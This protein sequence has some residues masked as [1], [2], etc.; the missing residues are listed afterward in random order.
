MIVT[1]HNLK[2]LDDKK[3]VSDY[4]T[5]QNEQAFSSL[6]NSKTPRLYKTALRLTQNEG[7]A[8]EIIQQMWVVA[9]RKLDHFEWRSELTTWLT[10]ILFNLY[11]TLRKREEKMTELAPN[12]VAEMEVIKPNK[13]LSMDLESAISQLPPGYRQSIILHDIEGFKHRE[14]AELL[15]IS[16]GTSKSQLF[17]ARK[18]IREYLDDNISNHE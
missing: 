14:I 6:Y 8:Q 2:T 4:L 1:N 16:E 11:R 15:D 7:Q 10:A 18:A 3:L 5:T 9:I 12:H 17:Y 13:D